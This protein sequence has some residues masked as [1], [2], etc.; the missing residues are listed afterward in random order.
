MLHSSICSSNPPSRRILASWTTGPSS[1]IWGRGY[2]SS[3]MSLDGL[4]SL[5]NKIQS[6]S[7]IFD[8]RSKRGMRNV[9]TTIVVVIIPKFSLWF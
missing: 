7:L 4:I 6:G 5:R 3:L 8:I 2:S 1:N 9:N